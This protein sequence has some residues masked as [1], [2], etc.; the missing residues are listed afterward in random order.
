MLTILA[1]STEYVL[2]PLSAIGPGGPVNP[3]ADT[4]QFAF[5]PTTS[6]TVS[7]ASYVTGTWLVPVANT[8]YAACNIGP[9]GTITLTPG[10]YT[11]WVKVTDNPEVPVRT[12]GQ[13]QIQ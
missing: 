3:T 13:I 11:V 2:V 4:V 8:Y 5:V 9:L 6:G 1:Q 12:P 10:I 7:P